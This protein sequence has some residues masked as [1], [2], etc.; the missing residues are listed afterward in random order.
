MF[1]EKSAILKQ[2]NAHDTPNPVELGA[3]DVEENVRRTLLPQCWIIICH[4]Q[5]WTQYL[6]LVAKLYGLKST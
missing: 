4:I 6:W 5:I 2:I 3:V 1:A